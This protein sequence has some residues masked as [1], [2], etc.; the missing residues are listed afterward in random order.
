MA[1]KKKAKKPAAKAGKSK[2]PAKRAPPRERLASFFRKL[3]KQPALMEKFSGSA[4]GREQVLE[5]SDLTVEH[6]N[7]LATGCLRDI[8]LALAGA[9]CTINCTVNVGDD[10]GGEQGH[11][12]LCSHGDCQ[13]FRATKKG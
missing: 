3:Y 12:Q 6:R 2:A 9:D 8:I 4:Q 7:V 10:D 11:S 5:K 1:T 13:A